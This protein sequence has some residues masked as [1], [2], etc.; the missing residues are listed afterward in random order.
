MLVQGEQS[1]LSLLH[2]VVNG[3]Q[4][5]RLRIEQPA[6][7]DDTLPYAR[8]RRQDHQIR[9]LE[10]A[11]QF[12]E[13]GEAGGHAHDIALVPVEVVDAIDHA[14][15]DLADGDQ[16]AADAALRD[17][18]DELLG[19][20]HHLVDIIRLFIGQRGDLPGG[21]D[22]PAEDGRALDDVGIVLDVDGRGDAVDQRRD[23]GRAA[24]LVQ[25][26]APFQLVH[27]GDEVGRLALLVQVEDRLIDPAVLLPIKIVDLK[28]RGDLDDR[29]GIDEQ[30]AKDGLLGFR[31]GRDGL[32]ELIHA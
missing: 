29:I 25:D 21:A 28:K 12:V 26:V 13:L 9:L 27:Q 20:V 17:V 18:E 32:V 24:H 5:P 15:H 14:V 16:I 8:S 10:P 7:A 6:A 2:E 11:Q 3:H 22:Q 19:P 31:I 23:V 30:G 4:T 1:T